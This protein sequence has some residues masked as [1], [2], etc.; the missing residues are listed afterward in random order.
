PTEQSYDVFQMLAGRV[1][2]ELNK[3]DSAVKTQ[4]PQV[5]QMLQKQRLAPIKPEPLDP[6]KTEEKPKSQQP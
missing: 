5:N 6:N 3:L 2:Q 1:D 4:L